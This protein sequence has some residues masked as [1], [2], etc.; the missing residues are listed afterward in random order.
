MA[1]FACLLFSVPK[2]E[3][4]NKYQNPSRR[5]AGD[6]DESWSDPHLRLLRGNAVKNV[7]KPQC[8]LSVSQVCENCRERGDHD[9]KEN[10]KAKNQF[11]SGGIHA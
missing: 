1:S 7:S 8:S 2:D 6:R 11:S 9:S 10:R 3:E 4:T 5:N